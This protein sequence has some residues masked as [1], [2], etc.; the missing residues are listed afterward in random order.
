MSTQ[1]DEHTVSQLDTYRLD[2]LLVGG[3]SVERSKAKFVSL[4]VDLVEVAGPDAREYYGCLNCSD[5]ILVVLLLVQ[6]FL[7]V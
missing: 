1:L 5:Y 7:E 3:C 4:H 2:M 6:Y